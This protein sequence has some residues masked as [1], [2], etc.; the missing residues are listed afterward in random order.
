MT[1]TVTS[2]RSTATPTKSGR[3]TP[4]R[5]RILWYAVL[6]LLMLAGGIAFI[7]RMTSGLAVTNL[8]STTPWGA[9][10]AFYIFFV[11]LSAGAFLLSSLVYV[12]GMYQFERIGR[13]AL[14]SAIISMGVALAF[15]A[16]D[17]GRIERSVLPLV[18]FHW[19][20]PLS[21]EV[22]FYIIY[23]VLLSAEL[24]IAVRLHKGLSKS[25][26]RATRRLRLLG[27]IGVPLAIFGV[28]GGTGTIFAVVKARGMWF[29]GLFPVIFVV[30]AMVSGTALL[31]VIHYVQSRGSG[32]RPDQA[33]MKNLATVLAGVLCVD[34]GLMFYEFIVPLLAFQTHDGDVIRVITLGPMW[35]S[36]WIVQ[37]L[38]G[39]IIPVAVLL[40]PRLRARPGVVASAAGLVVLGIVAVRFN[41]VVPALIPGVIDGLPSGSYL[42]SLVEWVLSLGLIAGGAAAYSVISELLPIHD[43]DDEAKAPELIEEA[44]A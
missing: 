31:A 11:G 21:W 13:A 1:T 36:F 7:L 23:I 30:S 37:L 28:H 9:W 20:S 8:S 39:M 33:L 35:W 3:A 12:F 22:R 41:I 26:V 14:L 27:I 2:S 18:F 16:V 38:V 19:T 34:L 15:I 40:T 25:P 6:G 32:R 29:G 42:P 10:V 44:S 17:L 43:H 24:A 5:L 4:A